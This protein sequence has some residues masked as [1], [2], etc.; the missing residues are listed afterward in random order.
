MGDYIV[1]RI[2]LISLETRM[3]DLRAIKYPKKVTK[4]LGYT[5]KSMIS[6]RKR[7]MIGKNH[8]SQT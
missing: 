8:P 4:F 5:T 7:D 6:Y 3:S 1:L 2:A